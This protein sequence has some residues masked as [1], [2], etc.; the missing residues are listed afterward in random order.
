MSSGQLIDV[1]KKVLGFGGDF[2]AD[3]LSVVSLWCQCGRGGVQ[4]MQAPWPSIGNGSA[5]RDS[6][7]GEPFWRD[8]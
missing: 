3:Y 2:L 8:S 7:G 5:V 6:I 1:A 4:F